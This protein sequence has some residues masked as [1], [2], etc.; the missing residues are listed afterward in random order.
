MLS[1]AGATL[2]NTQT[3]AASVEA[4]MPTPRGPALGNQASLR[5]LQAKLFVGAAEDPLEHEAD[6]VA[7]QVMRMRD[8]ALRV[9]ASPPRISRKCATCEEED[10]LQTKR[11]DAGSAGEEAPAAVDEALRSPGRPLDPAAR[12]FLEP[13]LG[14]SF[15]QVRVHTDAPAAESARSVGARAYTVGRDI[16][17]AEGGYA[18][19][20]MA[21]RQL[22]ADELTHVVQ[23]DPMGARQDMTATVRRVTAPDPSQATGDNPDATPA[24]PTAGAAS[25]PA[26]PATPPAAATSGPAA[27]QAATGAACADGVVNQD[28]DPLPSAPAFTYQLMSGPAVFAAVTKRDA[29]ITAHPLGASDPIF[30]AGGLGSVKV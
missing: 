1:L 4:R 9:S 11:V 8:P 15:D 18:P 20:S 27:A 23:Q 24:A 22:I 2:A 30:A 5:R 19:D 17:F 29:S 12:S 14:R 10:R 3:A 7:A 6:A 25:Q 26:S 28:Q 21:G 13:R 16:V